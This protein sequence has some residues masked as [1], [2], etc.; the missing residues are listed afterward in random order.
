MKMTLANEITL[1]RIA[2]IAPFVI[3]M[4]KLHEAPS[5]SVMRLAAL[6]IFL[7][8]A[9][10]DG[11]DGYI[12]RRRKQV[13]KLGA[14]L[15]PMADKLLMMCACILLSNPGTGIDGFV[16]PPTVVVLIIGKDVLLFLGFA[17]TYLVTS[18]VRVVPVLTGKAGT[19]LQLSMVA[20]ILLAPDI[21]PHL[22]A[23]W[24]FLRVLWWS[25]AGVAVASAFI[26]I[27]AGI[28]YIE[29]FEN[30]SDWQG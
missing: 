29:H 8:M 5:S 14:F 27:R 21:Y 6:G 3:C 19:V 10:S 4:L 18:H 13:T 17:I 30:H 9:I 1:L 23:W 11:V 20:G 28:G 22:E 12:A 7:V 24:W 15:D 2:L 26:Y 25:A 16:L